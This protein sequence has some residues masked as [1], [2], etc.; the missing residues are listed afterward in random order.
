MNDLR[1]GP[2][3]S[4]R[5]SAAASS[6][7]PRQHT[8]TV[9]RPFGKPDAGVDDRCGPAR[10]AGRDRR[11]DARAQLR[12]DLADDDRRTPPRRTSSSSVPRVCIR[13]RAAPLSRDD[14]A[15]APD[16]TR[17]PLTSLTIA[18]P[19]V[20]RRRAPRRPCRCRSRS[21]SAAVP[22]R[23]VERPAARARALPSADT[24]SAPGPRRL[25][26][27]VDDVGAVGFHLRAPRAT[28]AP[29]SMTRAASAKESGVTFRMPMTSAA[30]AETSDAATGRRNVEQERGGKVRSRSGIRNS[31]SATAFATPIPD[32][33]LPT[34]YSCGSGLFSAGTIGARSFWRGAR[35]R[36][37]RPRRARA[38][39]CGS[40]SGRPAA[41]RLT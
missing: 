5:S 34:R 27:D 8:I 17:R 41:R 4:G 10:H 7:K 1:D 31:E 32:C 16:R 14:R 22:R 33:K 6:G 25:A 35:L 28:A 24:G 3:S 26:A 36:P 29:G 40:S 13:T 20:E 38:T 11:G 12:R 37:R 23:A 18:A 21:G 9:R 15:R 39:G 2:T 30:L 19:A